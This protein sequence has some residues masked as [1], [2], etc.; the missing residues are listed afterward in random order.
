M[1]F[2]GGEKINEVTQHH[3]FVIAP[4]QPPCAWWGPSS[5]C[6]ERW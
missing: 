1:V 4:V 3:A 5:S 2:R 6:D